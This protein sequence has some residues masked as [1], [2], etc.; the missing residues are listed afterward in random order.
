M[1]THGNHM[2]FPDFLYVDLR[3][4]VLILIG[5]FKAN[6]ATTYRLKYRFINP[7]MIAANIH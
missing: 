7:K 4:R 1:E 3:L 5:F 2:G 6:M